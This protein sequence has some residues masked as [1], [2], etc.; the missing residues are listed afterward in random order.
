MTGKRR[1]GVVVCR[2][3][4]AERSAARCFCVG[5]PT[6]GWLPGVKTRL[7]ALVI[8]LS[9]WASPV[10][11][12]GDPIP[13]LP[14]A[15][16][17]G[18]SLVARQLDG[19]R[20]DLYVTLGPEARATLDERAIE[21]LARAALEESFE[22]GENARSV[23]PWVAKDGRW[24]PIVEL[25][26]PPPAVP[27]KDFELAPPTTGHKDAVVTSPGTRR[28][29]ALSG[30]VVYVSA[31]HGFTWD[32]ALGRWA[33][34]RG[35]THDIVEDLVS[36]E[37]INQLL[38]TY[39]E[40]AGATVFTV[41]ERDS[42]PHMVIVDAGSGGASS[43]SGTSPDISKGEYLEIQGTWTDSTAG[44]FQNGL[45]PYVGNVNAFA[46]GASRVT[47]TSQTVTATAEWR[48]EVPRSGDYQVYASW[49]AGDN[50]APD[51]R[52]VVR[53][54]G[55][56]ATRRVDQRRH[57]KTWV[58]LGRYHFRAGERYAVAL[59][60]DSA[61][62]NTFVSADAIRVGGGMGDAARGTDAPAPRS[63][64]STRPRWEENARYHI[65]FSGAPSSVYA[66]A[67]DE[68]SDDV[69]S[70]SRYAAWQ[71]EA[72]EDS[73]YIAWHTN[74]P[75]PGVGTST[76]IYGPNPP[77]GTY[78]FTGTAGSERLGRLL[79]DEVVNDMKRGVDAGWRDRG[80][81]TAYFGEVN[82]SH[83]PEMPAALCEV[84]FH[85]TES[86][87]TRLKDPKVRNIA[88]RAFAQAVVKYFA[89]KDGV[90]VALSP[91]PPTAFAVT[92]NG[93]SAT[94]SFEPP[95]VDTVGLGGQAATGYRL[96]RS[97]D[98]RAFD[99]GVD[100]AVTAV[101][102]RMQHVVAG[103]TPGELTFFRV[104]AFNDG[105]ESM[106]S[107]VLGV[108]PPCMGRP[109]AL[110]VHGFHR[111]DVGLGAR[112]DLSTW[113]LGVVARLLLERMNRFDATVGHAHALAALQ[114]PFDSVE[115]GV[116]AP[117][118]ALSAYRLIGVALGEESTADE[119]LS[120]A[121]Q[122]ALMAWL[123]AGGARTLM[124]SGA[125]LAWDLGARGTEADKSFLARVG[126]AFEAD[127]AGTYELTSELV[128]G[129]LL[130]DDGGLGT[131]DVEF[132]DTLTPI[133]S[134]VVLRY[135]DGRVAGV[136]RV[137][138]QT[139]ALTFGVPLES[140]FPEQRR[141]ALFEALLRDVEVVRLEATCDGSVE[142]G[143]ELEP[144][145]GPEAPVEGA[146]G[147]DEAEVVEAAEG[148]TARRPSRAVHS[149]VREV[150]GCGAAGGGLGLL[151]FAALALILR[152]VD[153]ASPRGARRLRHR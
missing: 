83:N 91:E 42:N 2:G 70:R 109:G 33:T 21:E 39:L 24:V 18:F 93:P 110:L 152:R 79:H 117:A 44:G 101:A 132:P 13:P 128:D 111:L 153:F 71:N 56:E 3:L 40:N 49:A 112:E 134:E 123:D 75:N 26:P 37:T 14:F 140:L 20:L 102:G 150:G 149:S 53:H 129:T 146:E 118:V 88:A 45:A 108:N 1:R 89:E 114:I 151:S 51:A 122:A 55:G 57:G 9:L 121:E 73:V 28:R 25:L 66:Y 98:G 104:T 145:P 82:P 138:G 62:P 96:Y 131:Y 84:A 137:V 17:Q 35:N 78:N 59:M 19:D 5:P 16:P 4:R 22:A 141:E 107:T 11:A 143:P 142:P 92:A 7:S 64:L 136:R 105:G 61:T 103:L 23:L 116:D 12:H 52:Y 113:S 41:R 124:L 47:P 97:R 85:S 50:R 87:A 139:T 81:Y 67:A 120:D 38:T 46:Q 133:E 126:A 76:F 127:D 106:P 54:G 100:I 86:D 119:T 27:K 48:F 99:D 135:A 65:Q 115:G 34:Q 15:L 94:I 144:E 29:G 58:A 32:P 77:D 130:L 80:L 69:G 74:A 8:V 125:E 60:N 72:G 90:P 147:I 95:A 31:G 43:Q 148:A 6:C 63:R 68:R 10:A 30:K 36:A